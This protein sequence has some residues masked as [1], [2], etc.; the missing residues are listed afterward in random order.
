MMGK[1][2]NLAFNYSTAGWNLE[3]GRIW[4]QL[5]KRIL[6]E[7]ER[8]FQQEMLENSRGFSGKQMGP[9]PAH[10]GIFFFAW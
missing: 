2:G 8:A 1:V 4:K 7:E 9:H 5:Q 10:V 3:Q 6:E